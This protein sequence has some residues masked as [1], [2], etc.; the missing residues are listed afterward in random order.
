MRFA[1]LALAVVVASAHAVCAAGTKPPP[2]PDTY[3]FDLLALQPYKGNFARLVKTEALPDWVK[4][5][6][7]KGEGE[8][9]PSKAIDIGGTPYRLDHVC[10]PHD[11]AGN[12]LDVLWAPAGRRVWAALVEGGKP[13]V[14]LGS[15]P[16]PQAKALKDPT[17][18]AVAVIPTPPAAPAPSA[19][20]PTT[21]PPTA[22]TTTSTAPA[23]P[24]SSSPEPDTYIFDVLPLQPYKGNLARLV[25]SRGTPDWVKAISTKGEGTA[26]PS[27]TVDI[28]GTPYRLDLVCKPHAC[29][30]NTL[31]VLWAPGGHKV[32][33]ALV[34]GGKPPVM[35]GAPPAPQAKALA[36]AVTPPAPAPA[37][38]STQPIQDAPKQD[39]PKQDAP[40]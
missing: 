28:A 16:A 19:V 2:E 35:L 37:A 24:T 8:A 23:P 14:M 31:D 40:K 34:D 11:C 10:K 17:A 30:G 21:A 3:V 25:K 18:A 13:P 27:K 29:A 22:A 5:I 36:D 33:G 39:T 15:P 38:S 9:V 4:A 6:S 7:T 26:V 20:T 1:L 32:W 12:T